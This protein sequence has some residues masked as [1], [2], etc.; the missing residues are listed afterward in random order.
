[1]FLKFDDGAVREL[2][3]NAK[4]AAR[5]IVLSQKHDDVDYRLELSPD[6]PIPEKKK[7]VADIQTEVDRLRIAERCGKN[8]T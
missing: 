5:L 7:Q 8:L 1:M 3:F 2:P 6:L 4:L